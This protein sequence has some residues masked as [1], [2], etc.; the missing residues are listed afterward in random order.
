MKKRILA[1]I[2]FPLTL[3]TQFSTNAYS[4]IFQITNI[5]FNDLNPSLYDGT[6]TWNG[7]L[8]NISYTN[9][10]SANCTKVI[11]NKKGCGLNG[12]RN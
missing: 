11:I 5:D 7:L 2:L 9:K 6:I 1:I 8:G 10:Y 3:F 4:T 12:R